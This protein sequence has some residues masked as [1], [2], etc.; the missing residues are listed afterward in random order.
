SDAFI[1]SRDVRSAASA[2]C[3][4]TT[5]HRTIRVAV[6]QA[7][8]TAMKD[9]ISFLGTDK[10]CSM[11]HGSDRGRFSLAPTPP[12]FDKVLAPACGHLLSRAQSAFSTTDRAVSS[13]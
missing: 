13:R 9:R 3:S 1:T 12:L 6:P 5:H 8:I 11:A 7:P 10:F 2:R 4:E